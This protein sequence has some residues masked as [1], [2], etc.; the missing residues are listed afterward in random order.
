MLMEKGNK[1]IDVSA[2]GADS[3]RKMGYK[4]VGENETSPQFITPEQCVADIMA[5]LKSVAA[6]HGVDISQCETRRDI[7]AVFIAFGQGVS[8]GNNNPDFESMSDDD[9]T[10]YAAEHGVDISKARS[11]AAVIALLQ[12]SKQDGE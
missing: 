5:E 4:A 9:I 7:Y 12:K 3:Y 2:V 8:D 11:R 1:V 6:E 10:R